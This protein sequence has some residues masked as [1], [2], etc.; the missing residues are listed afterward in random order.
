MAVLLDDHDN[1]S[2]VKNPD[3]ISTVFYPASKSATHTSQQ[4]LTGSEIN[5]RLVS[6]R[7]FYILCS[8]F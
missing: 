4:F 3:D 7:F 1:F 8:H 6:V 2:L 5:A